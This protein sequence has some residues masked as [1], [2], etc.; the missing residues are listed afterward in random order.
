MKNKA[1][2]LIQAVIMVFCVVLIFVYWYEPSDKAKDAIDGAL[3]AIIFIE[4]II[5]RN[6]FKGLEK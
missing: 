3:L 2:E 1:I 5:T 6:K 4:L